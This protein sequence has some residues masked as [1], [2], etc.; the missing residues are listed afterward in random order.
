MTFA[1]MLTE[2]PRL[3][4]GQREIIA[5]RAR[6][7]NEGMEPS[8]SPLQRAEIEDRIDDLDEDPSLAVPWEGTME[9]V[10]KLR[11]DA[12]DKKTAPRRH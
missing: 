10:E 4:P 11:A 8:L 3:T 12:R 2:L 5:I 1:E 9:A 6:T 7:M